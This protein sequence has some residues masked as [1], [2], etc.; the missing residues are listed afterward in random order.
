MKNA[1]AHRV[2]RTRIDLDG[3]LL[4]DK[5]LGLSSNDALMK[6]KSIVS[7]AK[8]GHGGTLD[9]LATGLLPIAFGEATKFLH[10]MLDARKTYLADIKFGVVTSTADR[11]GESLMIRQVTHTLAQLQ[12]T[13]SQFTGNIAQIPPMFSALKVDGVPLYKLARQGIEVERQPRSV[14]IDSIELVNHDFDSAQI[15]VTCSKGTYIRTLAQDIGETLGCGAHLNGLRREAVFD[16]QMR[17]DLQNAVSLE[18]LRAAVNANVL[19]TILQASDTMIA[20]LPSVDLTEELASRF[21]LGQRLRIDDKQ[22]SQTKLPIA[23]EVRVYCGQQLLG[24]ANL[25]NGHLAPKRLIKNAFTPK[26][27]PPLEQTNAPTAAHE[28]A[29]V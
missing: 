28:A 23:C 27:S 20:A 9:P 19:N 21:C 7:A 26:I 24:L 14:T 12:L 22:S 10:G 11:E 5:P 4:L 29:L 8:A 2:K 15:R 16:G 17:F 18:Q 13:L 3:V 6:A 25:D 1:Q